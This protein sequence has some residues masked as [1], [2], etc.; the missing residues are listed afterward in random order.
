MLLDI[1]SDVIDRESDMQIVGCSPESDSLIECVERVRPDVLIVGLDDGEPPTLCGEVLSRFP[2]VKV[3]AISGRARH[4]T[5][6]ELRPSRS[7]LG[8]VSPAELV[9]RIRQ[10]MG[11]MEVV[12]RSADG[13]VILDAS[14]DGAGPG[15][16]LTVAREE[17]R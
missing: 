12:T 15:L 9:A 4:V 8:E 14:A 10:A 17:V 2:H 16:R 11:P 3:L 13:A 1:L 7:V 6:Y 5:L